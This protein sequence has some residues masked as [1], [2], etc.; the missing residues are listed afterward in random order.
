MLLPLI[1]ALLLVLLRLALRALLRLVLQLLLLKLQL[2]LVLLRALL[3]RTRVLALPPV[4]ALV[5][6]PFLCLQFKPNRSRKL[7][8][9]GQRSVNNE[10]YYNTPVRRIPTQPWPAGD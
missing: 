7:V 4:P 2:L 3:Q 10:R 6:P 5:L 8:C 9:E 1:L